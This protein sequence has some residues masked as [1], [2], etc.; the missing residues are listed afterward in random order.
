M[1]TVV[2]VLP[3]EE[4]VDVAAELALAR[5]LAA[6]RAWSWCPVGESLGSPEKLSCSAGVA[7]GERESDGS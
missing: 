6:S 5:T 3:E 7:Y 4:V 2:V 1:E